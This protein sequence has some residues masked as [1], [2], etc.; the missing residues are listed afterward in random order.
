MP[1]PTQIGIRLE[2]ELVARLDALVP[3]LRTLWSEP[4]R[5]DIVRACILD[6]LPRL[7]A[8]AQRI[9]AATA[10]PEPEPGDKQAGKPRR[11][12]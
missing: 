4:T 6:A 7:E 8:Q 5:S 1:K 9:A 12:K 10:E 11:G 2:D 3:K